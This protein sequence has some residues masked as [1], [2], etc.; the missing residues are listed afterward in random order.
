[1]ENLW[2]AC[3]ETDPSL[4]SKKVFHRHLRYSG[5]SFPQLVKESIRFSTGNLWKRCGKPVEKIGVKVCPQVPHRFPTGLSTGWILLTV[6]NFRI[7]K[8]FHSFHRPDDDDEIFNYYLTSSDQPD[9]PDRYTRSIN[10]CE[11]NRAGLI[12]TYGN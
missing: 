3:G 7:F 10:P 2:R 9:L 12:R 5:S 11:R 6:E 8:V 4:I 1:M